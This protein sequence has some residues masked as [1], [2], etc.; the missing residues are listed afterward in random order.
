MTPHFL[1]VQE[2]GRTTRAIAST[3]EREVAWSIAREAGGEGIR[4][5]VMRVEGTETNPAIEL[6]DGF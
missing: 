3:R 2:L 6:D 4:L 5:Y 1:V